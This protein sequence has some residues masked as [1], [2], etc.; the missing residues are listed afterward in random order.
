MSVVWVPV[1][2]PTW[3]FQALTFSC[4]QTYLTNKK[5]NPIP[6]SPAAG[7]PLVTDTERTPEQ[8]LKRTAGQTRFTSNLSNPIVHKMSYQCACSNPFFHF[9]PFDLSAKPR[10]L[11]VPK[12]KF[13][14]KIITV[15]PKQTV[16][17]TCEYQ[18][19]S[20][21]LIN[22]STGSIQQSLA[23]LTFRWAK[24]TDNL[25]SEGHLTTHYQPI[26]LAPDKA[27]GNLS[28]S[29]YTHSGLS[30][31]SSLSLQI[32][33]PSD[34]GLVICEASNFVGHSEQ[35]C[36][37]L[38]KAPLG[39][40]V[41]AIAMTEPIELFRL[42]FWIKLMMRDV[43]MPLTERLK[44]SAWNLNFKVLD[45]F[46]R[47]RTIYCSYRNKN[48]TPQGIRAAIRMAKNGREW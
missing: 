5:V 38:L 41:C 17:L 1:R 8:S 42:T 28:K 32:G 43:Q 20:G 18:L 37:F 44:H 34:Y 6:F 26:S 33:K 4:Y 13:Q 22:H 45:K 10:P 9:S 29:I 14:P 2:I 39:M 23:N 3:I 21:G 46:I 40:C 27:A 47:R 31:E 36:K 25:D 24:Q 48:G 19:S 35:P 16:K 15:P 12:C 11:D 7:R 30:T